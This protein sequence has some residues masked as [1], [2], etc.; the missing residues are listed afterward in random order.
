MHLTDP[1]KQDVQQIRAQHITFRKKQKNN[2][3]TET[4]PQK[5]KYTA[6]DIPT[7]IIITLLII[8]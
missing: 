2:T 7:H 8:P 5:T 6:L 4:Y 3:V 1:S